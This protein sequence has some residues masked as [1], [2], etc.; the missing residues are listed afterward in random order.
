MPFGIVGVGLLRGAGWCGI[1]VQLVSTWLSR[2]PVQARAGVDFLM[3]ASSKSGVLSDRPISYVS[4]C[5][6]MRQLLAEVEGVSPEAYTLYSCKATVLSRALQLRLLENDRAKQGHHRGA[7]NRCVS[8]YGRDDVEPMLWFQKEVQESVL[9]GWRPH[10][11]QM[12]G[13][14]PP[15]LEHL[16][17]LEPQTDSES[18][19]ESAH[20]GITEIS[21]SMAGCAVE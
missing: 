11:M 14:L 17:E 5:I 12:R 3:P 6:Y 9:G 1:Y 4:A 16:V 18:E 20:S 2:L 15:L 10:S 19:A 7:G 8:L 13:T 21:K